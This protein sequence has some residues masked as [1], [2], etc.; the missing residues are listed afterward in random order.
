MPTGRRPSIAAARSRAARAR[1]GG[2]PNF[3]SACPVE[4]FSCVSAAHVGC[5][6]NEDLLLAARR[7]LF[8][9]RQL[10]VVVDDDQRDA[11]GERPFEL[12]P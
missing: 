2:R 5:D 6:A 3:E 4:I 9:R 7:E 10:V 11:R 12:A 8:E 1:S